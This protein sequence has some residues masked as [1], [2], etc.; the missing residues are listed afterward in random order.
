MPLNARQI[1]LVQQSFAKVEPIAAQAAKIFYDKLFDFDPALHDLFK[2][3]MQ[4]QGRKLMAVL[5]TAVASLTRLDQL[6]AVLQQLAERHVGYGVTI[7]DYTT[8]GN[9]LL[10]TLKRGLGAE[11]TPE[12]RDAWIAVYQLV[13]D[14]M[15]THAYPGFAPRRSATG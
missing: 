10:F 4:A 7:E 12:T 5:K 6:V 11:F 9:A 15:R 1:Q 2:G 14:T 8:V 13:A 3:D